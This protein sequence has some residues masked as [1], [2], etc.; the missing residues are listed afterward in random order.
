ML[1]LL[2][3]LENRFEMVR[4]LLVG[5]ETVLFVVGS[6]AEDLAVLGVFVV[7]EFVLVGIFRDRVRFV[8]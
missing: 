2:A 1:G 4:G 8:F 7:A 5:I 3:V 6:A